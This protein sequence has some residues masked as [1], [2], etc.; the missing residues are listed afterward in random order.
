MSW[1]RV[2]RGL[3]LLVV[4]VCPLADA[5]AAAISWQAPTLDS[6]FTTDMLT[7]GTFFDS[8]TANATVTV[9]TVTFNGQASLSGG[10]MT[11]ANGSQ[12]A[13]HNL[14]GYT[15]AYSTSPAGWDVN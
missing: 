12:I 15:T 5:R 3:G 10:T 6:G 9:G 14:N 2:L 11:F 8:A 13:V 7:T 1:T 4:V